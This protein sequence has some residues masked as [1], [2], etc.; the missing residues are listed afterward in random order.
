[1]PRLS[2]GLPSFP[3]HLNLDGG[4]R[5]RTV[6]RLAVFFFARIRTVQLPALSSGFPQLPEEHHSFCYV[7]V[8]LPRP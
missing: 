6:L 5:Q 2:P 7:D 8:E 1:V 3:G 4:D